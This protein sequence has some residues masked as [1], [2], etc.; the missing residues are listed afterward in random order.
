MLRARYSND[1]ATA[2]TSPVVNVA[3]ADSF[4]AVLDDF[5]VAFRAAQLILFNASTAA[6]IT[7]IYQAV[8]IGQNAYIYLTLGVN[9]LLLTAVAVEMV[10]TQ[11]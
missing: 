9:I 8:H 6:P 2:V 7:G 10:H 5:L 11:L 1:T 4:T 3:Y